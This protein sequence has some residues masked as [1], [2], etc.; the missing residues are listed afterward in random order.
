ME[1]GLQMSAGCSVWSGREVQHSG[2]L[3]GAA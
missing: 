1:S 2:T 3:A